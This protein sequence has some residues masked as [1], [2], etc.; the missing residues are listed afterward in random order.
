[1]CIRDSWYGVYEPAKKELVYACAG[2]PPALLITTAKPSQPPTVQPLKTRGLPIGMFAEG[3]YGCDR[4]SIPIHST[5]YLF[6]DG[7]FELPQ[8]DGE[9]WGLPAFTE[10]LQH[11]HAQGHPQL[12]A[13]LDK[14]KTACTTAEF[15]D[16]LSLLQV[17]F[18]P[19]ST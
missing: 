10:S 13:I 7:I 17:H 6:S 1:M 16:D 12:D 15:M 9:I 5:L 14:S 8:P 19:D 2:H 3:R 11:F 4:I 18:T